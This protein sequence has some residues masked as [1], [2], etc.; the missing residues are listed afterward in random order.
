MIDRMMAKMVA[1]LLL[2]VLSGKEIFLKGKKSLYCI[3]TH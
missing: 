1:A 2:A 3:S